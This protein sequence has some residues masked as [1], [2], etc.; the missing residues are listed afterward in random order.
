MEL[1]IKNEPSEKI[2]ENAIIKIINDNGYYVI[3]NQAS[4]KTGSG[5]PDLSACI[6]GQYWGIEVKAMRDNV[7]TTQ[8]QF[9]HLQAIAASGGRALYTKTSDLFNPDYDTHVLTGV[10]LHDLNAILRKKCVVMV[11]VLDSVQ[12]KIYQKVDVK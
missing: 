9:Q 3:K 11:E 12:I 5:R 10:D 1:N 6:K 8:N 4:S 7:K 2:V